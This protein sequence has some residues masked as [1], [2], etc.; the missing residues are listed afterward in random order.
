MD[1]RDL[2]R[3]TRWI[4]RI[5][6]PFLMLVTRRD[7][8]GVEK[9]PTDGGFV[10]APNH[11]SHLDPILISHFM[12]DHGV[13]PRFLAKDTLFA[14]KGLGAILTAA[15]QIPVHRS[16]EGAAQSLRSAVA[17]VREGRSVRIYPEG[18]I[19]RDPQLWP[20]SGRTGAVRVA[21]ETGRPLV[22]L[23]QWGAHEILWP[24]TKVP[25]FLPRK[26]IHV[27]VGDPV[28]LSDLAGRPIDEHVLR[29][30]TERLM[31]VLTAMVGEIRGELP[32][33]PR[34][35]VHT[36]ERPRTAYRP[37][38]GAPETDAPKEP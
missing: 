32:T 13:T 16:T 10:L 6:R 38:E 24:Y 2:P 8:R 4:V 30:A 20:M 31:D 23:A 19:T 27:V 21:L 35:D 34:I 29:T 12:V 28:D 25:R 14:V 15:E 26:T 1:R 3:A 33:G 22:P 36:L 37:V 7:W 18:T 5:L 11:I 17:A 9:L